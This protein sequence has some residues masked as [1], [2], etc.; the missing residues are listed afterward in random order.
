MFLQSACGLGS[1]DASDALAICL[2]EQLGLGVQALT[3]V[4]RGSVLD[5]FSGDIGPEITQHSLQVRPGQHISGTRF[6]GY[7]S[8]GCD[9]NCRLDM[10][11]FELVTLREISAGELLTIDYAST[12]DRLHVQFPCHCGADSC[13]QWI[14]GR[15][16]PV[17]AEGERYLA[18]RAELQRSA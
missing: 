3:D 16:D 15:L 13:R 17:S 1:P 6:I 4:T 5:N 7:L 2:T 14:T 9:P 11:S 18:M 8:H 10:E 12:E